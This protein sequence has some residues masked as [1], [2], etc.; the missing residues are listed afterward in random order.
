M[1]INKILERVSIFNELAQEDL[2]SIAELC[3]H[4][5]YGANEVIFAEKS[6]G[7]EIYIVGKGQVRIELAIKGKTDYAT[8]HR[9][10]EGE[11]FGELAIVSR[12]HRSGTARTE[13]DCEVIAINRK[14]LLTLFEE[15]NRI[16]YIVAMNL[17]SLL[18][19]RLKKTNLQLIACF[20]WE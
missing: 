8:V 20:L 6:E 7:T 10:G 3:E 1:D 12:G 19:T 13:T 15:H 2:R 5:K 16:G 14:S 17:A 18:A 11:V 4:R 9:V